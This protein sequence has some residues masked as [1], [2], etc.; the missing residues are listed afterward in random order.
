MS[1]PRR[2]A[3]WSPPLTPATMPAVAMNA[4]RILAPAVSGK[5]VS[6]SWIAPRKLTPASSITMLVEMT[7]LGETSAG[8]AATP[9]AIS[10]ASSPPATCW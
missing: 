5:P 1:T 6:A 2:S 3:T 7:R 4:S 8:V 10:V 9:T